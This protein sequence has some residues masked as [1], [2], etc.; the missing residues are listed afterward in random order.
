MNECIFSPCKSYRYILRHDIDPLLSDGAY[1]MFVGLNPS[2]ADENNLDPTLR[3]IRSFTTREGLGSFVMANLFAFRATNPKVMKAHPSPIGI[4]NDGWI[5]RFASEAQFIV[6]AWGSHGDLEKRD[7]HVER[8]LKETRK[9]LYCFGRTASGKPL[10]PLY[11][12]DDTPL[13]P[14]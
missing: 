9:P 5:K 3:R 12:R 4:E 7:E 13:I 6:C 2:T 14:F 10:H 11:L 8:L 1:A